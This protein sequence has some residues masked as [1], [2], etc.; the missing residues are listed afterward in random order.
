MGI[1]Y[2]RMNQLSD[3]RSEARSLVSAG[4]RWMLQYWHRRTRPMA[5]FYGRMQAST[6]FRFFMEL[7]TFLGVMATI[8]SFILERWD[9]EHDRAH[10]AWT[11]VAAHEEGNIGLQD[12]LEF[13][14]DDYRLSS[15]MLDEAQLY[16]VQLPEANLNHS[17]FERAELS[18]S[19]LRGALLREAKLNDAKLHSAI[20]ED[21]DLT[22]ADLSGAKLISTKLSGAILEN[23]ILSDA[24]LKLADLSGANLT[25][26]EFGGAIFLG[27]TLEDAT[28]RD[29]WP[30]T[31]WFCKTTMP[32]GDINNEDCESLKEKCE[33]GPPE[34]DMASLCRWFEKNHEEVLAAISQ[35]GNI[36]SSRVEP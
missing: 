19:N 7:A 30:E 14:K 28:G 33:T 16:K 12:A 27:A 20:L 17:H 21:V 31:A 26:A 5:H 6:S 15:V 25:N 35:S 9:R 13:L 24:D 22:K 23:T 3:Y 36:L 10:K 34:A 2:H 18:E 29:R 1:S 32:N 11:L 8:I 4:Y